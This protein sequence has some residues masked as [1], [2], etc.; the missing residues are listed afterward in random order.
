MLGAYVLVALPGWREHCSV[1]R[2][3]GGVRIFAERASAG[4]G[5]H[6][7]GALGV[8]VDS[9]GKAP[10]IRE[11]VAHSQTSWAELKLDRGFRLLTAPVVDLLGDVAS[12]LVVDQ[13]MP[14]PGGSQ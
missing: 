1:R 3:C 13:T 9:A 12:L 10:A 7:I 8:L 2:N 5:L 4:G 11:L 6:S 14:L